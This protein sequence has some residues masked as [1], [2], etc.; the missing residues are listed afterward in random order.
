MAAGGCLRGR[1]WMDGWMDGAGWLESTACVRRYNDPTTLL[2]PL[3]LQADPQLLSCSLPFPPSSG[4]G[5]FIT[6]RSP[7]WL[8]S[9]SFLFLSLSLFFFLPPSL[10]SILQAYPGAMF[11]FQMRSERKTVTR[12]CVFLC[13]FLVF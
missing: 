6:R 10:T 13:G 7:L 2:T 1:G 12:P 3:T 5:P 4:P 11:S 8:F 9:L